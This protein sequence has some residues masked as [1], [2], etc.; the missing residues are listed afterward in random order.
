MTDQLRQWIEDN[1]LQVQEISEGIYSIGEVIFVL[2]TPKEDNKV[3]DESFSLI[4]SDLEYEQAE[5]ADYLLFKFGD[6]F[7]YSDK[8]ESPVLY[9]FKYFG[10]PDL[11]FPIKFP[12]LGVHGGYDL[13][14]GS[15][16]YSAWCKKAKWLGID[17][18]GICEENTLAGVVA[19]EE[20]C[21]KAGI[22][23][24]V[25]EMV[26]V[27]HPDGTQYQIKLYCK[28]VI[29]WKSLLRINTELNVKNHGFIYQENL[30]ELIEGLICVLTPDISL[31]L[32]YEDYRKA[33]GENLYYDFDTVEWASQSKEKITLGNLQEYLSNYTEKIQAVLIGDAYYLDQLDSRIRK[34][35]NSIGKV[36]FKNQSNY[37]NFKSFDEY[38]L[39]ASELFEDETKCYTLLEKAV[40]TTTRIFKDIDF[41]TITGQFYL[42]KYEQ[43]KEE[44][45]LNLTS[46]ELLWHYL[47]NNLDRKLKNVSEDQWQV[48]LDRID[49][50][51]EVI[52]RGGFIDYFL[53]LADMFRWCKLQGIWTG[54]GRGSAA[55]CLISYILDIVLVDP[56]KYGLLF[57]RFLNEGRLG[58]SLPDID[59]DVQGERRDEVKRY[60]EEKYGRD[61]VISIGTYGTFKLKNSIKDISRIYGVESIKANFTTAGLN[62]E[63]SYSDF[64]KTASMKP[65][66]KEFSQVFNKVIEDLPLFLNQPK[67]SSIHAAG[68]VIVPKE[69]GTVY[70]QL[71][72][73][74]T[75]GGHLVSEWEGG[76]I[77]TAGFL[78]CDILGVKQ[79]DKFAA[80]DK[81][82][83]R[84]LD[85]NTCFED[86]HLIN[87]TVF[88]YFRAGFNEDV[89][90]F[91]AAGLK[92]Y[93]KE[94][95]P[96]N[97]EDLI[98]TV[99]L[100]RPG[101][102][103]SGAHKR[104][105]K[106]KNGFE[107]AEYDEGTQHITKVT[108]GQI[109]YQ[110]QI[111]QVFRDVGG[112]SLVE[113]DDLR[114]VIS[115]TGMEM[116]KKKE[117][118]SKY[119]ER[120][121]EGGAK[122]GVSK[123]GCE[124]LWEKI[125]KFA[126]YS[127]NRSHAA[128]YAITGY[129]S[130]WY[131][132]EYPLQFWTV[133][134]EYAED[135][136]IA[137]RIVEIQKTSSITIAGID[138]NGSKLSFT[139]NVEKNTIYW[140]LNSVKWVGDKVVE[141]I[142]EER[143]KN[144]EFYSFEEFVKRT[145][146]Y[147]AINKR[148]I[149][150]LILTGAFD[151]IQD[152]VQSQESFTVQNRGDILKA[153]FKLLNLELSEEYKGCH[154][155]KE[156][157]WIIKQKELAGFGYIDYQKV[158]KRSSLSNKIS[159]F[160]ENN[161]IL[162]IDLAE[163]TLQQKALVAG[164]LNKVTE[165]NSKRGKFCQLDLVDNSDIIYITVWNESYESM[166]EEL[167]KAVGKII[168]LTG[169]IVLD[170]YKNQNVIH[171][172]NRTKIEIV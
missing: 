3:F 111:M 20:A 103:E 126:T 34:T 130:Q 94:L 36:N 37:Q 83:Q 106:I 136:E 108:H 33:F 154:L 157:E 1:K 88:E 43:S 13:C 168:L 79:L 78:K 145:K 163:H 115:K 39:S 172:D 22:K 92:A 66:I 52:K 26:T 71:P 51:F 116:S 65:A 23:S 109:I 107:S 76:Y 124:R 113:A 144:G 160:K 148:A 140:A 31:D 6:R 81:L 72:V 149:T 99:A 138:I 10:E 166:K 63:G 96:D 139:S 97:I 8:I 25:G 156:H 12:F 84:D 91:G 54:I 150:H 134:L 110:E 60:I 46:E 87:E 74:A 9:D 44:E 165:R 73:K 120:F 133:S 90:Q 125:E 153:Y 112:F 24:I 164:L 135:K 41:N 171:T 95:L 102:I 159:I 48:Y 129:Y 27:Q 58:K 64:F 137:G 85:H 146:G 104:Y 38:L 151:S 28:D 162:H 98:A 123:A 2:V 14:N 117:I 19:F 53:I 55:G 29:G 161:D 152:I 56:I 121:I 32:V 142:L 158:I 50:E 69:F 105:A 35:L 75:T 118:L 170:N 67:N 30:F 93:C 82:I 86:I 100:Y 57:E 17:K 16:T 68:V 11:I 167:K 127:F 7:Y 132:V 62:T 131:K 143:E 155:W 49:R 4:L 114:K 61:Y 122:N 5:S 128:C 18:L 119:I 89:F 101:P 169:N 77:D 42:P 21:Q 45:L 80:I 70:Q 141:S 15:R 59:S 47:T 40:Q 147:R